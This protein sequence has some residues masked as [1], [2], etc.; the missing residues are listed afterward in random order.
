MNVCIFGGY[1]S[2]FFFE[3]DI[4]IIWNYEGN[5]LIFNLKNAGAISGVGIVYIFT[6]PQFTPWFQWGFGVA[7][8]LDFCV[9]F[10]RSLF[11][12]F[13]KLVF[14]FLLSSYCLF[15]LDLRG[16]ISPLASSNLLDIHS[17]MTV[18]SLMK[19]SSL[20]EIMNVNMTE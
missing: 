10:C 7:Q 17:K 1:S 15:F 19:V 6:A 2:F 5:I 4:S 11:I 14:L 9:V 18:I 16:L 12:I 3:Q 8:S 20:L 13:R